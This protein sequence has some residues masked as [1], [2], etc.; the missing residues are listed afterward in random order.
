MTTFIIFNIRRY[1]KP[2]K[3]K[4][5]EYIDHDFECHITRSKSTSSYIG[6]KFEHIQYAYVWM[7]YHF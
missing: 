4:N 1:G 2:S 3:R 6:F 7:V 5:S